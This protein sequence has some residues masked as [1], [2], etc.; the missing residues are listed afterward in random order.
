[1]DVLESQS[2]LPGPAHHMFS[3]V[4]VMLLAFFM[5]DWEGERERDRE[6]E[7]DSMTLVQV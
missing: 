5:E 2:N 3:M 1:M 6:R 7:R 4:T